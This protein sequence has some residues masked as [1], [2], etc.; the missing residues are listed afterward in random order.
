MLSGFQDVSFVSKIFI[1]RTFLGIFLIFKVWYKIHRS[2]AQPS[3]QRKVSLVI[4]QWCTQG[5]APANMTKQSIQEKLQ[6]SSLQS[7]KKVKLFINQMFCQTL[8]LQI[9]S[10]VCRDVASF[11]ELSKLF[12]WTLQRRALQLY[13]D[14]NTLWRWVGQFG[15]FCWRS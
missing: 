10:R 15:W 11:V 13:L 14:T 4:L 5:Q 2:A 7:S 9:G 6:H 3:K 1:Y 12:F 8:M